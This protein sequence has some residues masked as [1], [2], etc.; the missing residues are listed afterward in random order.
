MKHLCVGIAIAITMA[1]YVHQ[2][3]AE[4]PWPML[5]TYC[6]DDMRRL[7]K[8]AETKELSYELRHEQNLSIECDTHLRKR[9]ELY[10]NLKASCREESQGLF[11]ANT[12]CWQYHP[13]ELEECIMRWGYRH[14]VLFEKEFSRACKLVRKEWQAFLTPSTKKVAPCDADFERVCPSTKIHSFT[15]LSNCMEAERTQLSLACRAYW[16]TYRDLT[17]N[18]VNNCK[19]DAVNLCPDDTKDAGVLSKCLVEHQQDLSRACEVTV[20]ELVDH[21]ARTVRTVPIQP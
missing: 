12:Q 21:H 15:D 13:A 11:H 6:G 8:T 1:F 10:Q 7:G 3:V 9:Y 5:S 19:D 17:I 4:E 2:A 14:D 16:P 18:V 20:M